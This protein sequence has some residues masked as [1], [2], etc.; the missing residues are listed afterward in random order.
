MKRSL[1]Q[2]VRKYIEKDIFLLPTAEQE[3]TIKVDKANMYTK[4]HPKSIQNISSPQK[5]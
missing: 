1:Q 2:I 3:H 4:K 5:M